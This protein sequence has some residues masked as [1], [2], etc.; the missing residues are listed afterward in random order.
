M[1]QDGYIDHLN[2]KWFFLTD[3]NAADVY[4]SLP[5]LE[6]K[7]IDAAVANDFTP[8]QFIDAKTGEAVGWEYDAVEE[9][10]RRL[11]CVVNWKTTSWDA[12]IPAIVDGQFDVGM[13]GITITDERKQQVDFSAPYMQ[14]QQF[15][16]VRADD[17]A[18]PRPRTSPPMRSCWWVRSRAPPASTPPS[19]ISSTATRP[20]RASSSSTTSALL[21]RRSSPAMWTW[22]SWTPP[23]AVASRR[24]PRQAQDE[25]DAIKSEDFGFIFR[26]SDLVAPFNAAIATMNRMVPEYLNNK[27]FFLYDPNRN[28]V[29]VGWGWDGV[30]PAHTQ[31]TLRLIP[32]PLCHQGP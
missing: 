17:A 8:L 26:R 2:T 5:D 32:P 13:D 30:I 29:S 19:T 16:L 25:G 4:D 10:C 18:S 7:I 22:C 11:N 3:A 1:K 9:M 14:S 20:T 15:M 28:G 12:M 6:G 27:W 23:P 24:Q 21:F 31:Q